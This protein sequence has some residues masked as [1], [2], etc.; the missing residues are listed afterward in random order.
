[1]K[2][3]HVLIIS[4]FLAVTLFVI[5]ANMRSINSLLCGEPRSFTCI[6]IIGDIWIASL[7]LIPVPIF[8]LITYF[9]REEVF[10]AWLRFTYWWVPLSFAIVLFSSSRQSANI[11]GISDQAIFG[12][13][14][15]GI[16]VIISLILITWKYFATRQ[17]KSN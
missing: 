1:M 15:W 9:L 12:V 16:Y 2:K 17:S 7:I 3:N 8:S 14:T 10:R 13:L 4:V 11:V 5:E 6:D